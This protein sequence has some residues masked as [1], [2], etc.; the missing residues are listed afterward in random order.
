M[1]ADGDVFTEERFEGVLRDSLKVPSEKTLDYNDA[2]QFLG[3]YMTLSILTINASGPPG[4]P[5]GG[6]LIHGAKYPFKRVAEIWN[7]I[8]AKGRDK[9]V[10]KVLNRVCSGAPDHP[11]YSVN[12][13]TRTRAGPVPFIDTLGGIIDMVVAT[14]NPTYG[15]ELLIAT[16]RGEFMGHIF[17]SYPLNDQE[18]VVRGLMPYGISRSPFYL[19][20]TC[21][22]PQ[23]AGGFV[24]ALFAR[25]NAISAERKITHIFTWP[26]KT[27]MG[28]F[29]AMNYTV[30]PKGSWWDKNYGALAAAVRSIYGESQLTD[31][32]L[33]NQFKDF[34]FVLRIL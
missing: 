1:L 18:G 30:I 27:M 15:R 6:P 28:R 33:K 16:R 21:M 12:D 13:T 11:F 24:D 20:G 17:V 32:I 9:I 5:W 22:P 31:Y 19:P 10:R 34:D 29:E 3:K 23:D 14:D 7:Q 26:L 25:I 4:A 8:V 2:L